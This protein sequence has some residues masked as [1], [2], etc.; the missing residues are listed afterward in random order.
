MYYNFKKQS[1]GWGCKGNILMLL[2]FNGAVCISQALVYLAGKYVPCHN[3]V[4]R[5]AP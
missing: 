1:P 5:K 2:G 3:K 4:R